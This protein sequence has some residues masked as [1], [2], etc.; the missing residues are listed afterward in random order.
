MQWPRL[1]T[2]NFSP[3]SAP[4]EYFQRARASRPLR[5][6][7]FL[8]ARLRRRNSTVAESEQ[9]WSPHLASCGHLNFAVLWSGTKLWM[10]EGRGRL[11][12]HA[13]TERVLLSLMEGLLRLIVVKR[14]LQINFSLGRLISW[15]KGEGNKNG[16]KKKSNKCKREEGG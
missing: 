10:W 11:L 14:W 7:C 3:G 13:P 12:P 16:R 4:G 15:R 5:G 8:R 9:V 1:H 2:P 6:G